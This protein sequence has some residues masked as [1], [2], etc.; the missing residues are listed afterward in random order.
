MKRITR[1]ALLIALSTVNIPLLASG[2]KGF[3][4]AVVVDGESRPEFPA[5]GTVYV[6]AVK[7]REYELRLTNP[8]GVRVAVALSVDGLNTLDAKHTDAQNASKWVLEPYE[9]QVI[10]GWQV[11]GST[12]RRFTFT[13]EK[14]S[15][16]AALGQTDNLG[17]IEAVF[18]K[19]RVTYRPPPRPMSYDRRE[20]ESRPLE[21]G[22]GARASE[23][24]AAQAAEGALTPRQKRDSGSDAP[25]KSQAAPSLSDDYA[26]T[27]MGDRTQHEV[28]SVNLDLDPRPVATARIRYE[29]RTQLAKLGVL[30]RIPTRREPLARREDASGFDRYCPEPASFR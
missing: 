18:Y 7:G 9:T 26:A 25:M 29:F 5:R 4:L 15:Y 19:E 27:G 17:V 23:P 22:A 10:S 24:P 8:L 6:E 20:N 1:T 28:Y 14:R 13:G 11:N 3:D 21:T 16:G 2:Q 12:A 30:P